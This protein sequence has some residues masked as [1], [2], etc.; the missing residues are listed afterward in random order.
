MKKKLYMYIFAC[1]DTLPERV[2]RKGRQGQR[3]T[4]E[5]T[6]DLYLQSIEL[7]FS[8]GRRSRSSSDDADV[9]RV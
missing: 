1:R 7:I 2:Y 8:M 4:D 6:T 5:R 3:A 9:I